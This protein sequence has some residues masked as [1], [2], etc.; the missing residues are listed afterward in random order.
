[1]GSDGGGSLNEPGANLVSEPAAVVLS[2]VLVID[3]VRGVLWG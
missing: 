3:P 2:S 1:M